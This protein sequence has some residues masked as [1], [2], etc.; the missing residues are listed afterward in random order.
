MAPAKEWAGVLM[1][2]SAGFGQ[3]ETDRS[4]AVVAPALSLSQVEV[5]ALWRGPRDI[6][7]SSSVVQSRAPKSF[8]FGSWYM[9]FSAVLL[10]SSSW[11][12]LLRLLLSGC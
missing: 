3:I 8:A 11:R 4:N 1:A 10:S 9:V 6:G 12:R 7:L 2:S 5:L